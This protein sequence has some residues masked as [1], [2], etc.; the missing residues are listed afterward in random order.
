MGVTGV[1]GAEIG[2]R[3]DRALAWEVA[4]IPDMEWSGGGVDGRERDL[5]SGGEVLLVV[6]PVGVVGVV[7]RE[8]KGE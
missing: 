6:S 4:L 1:G 2:W 3:E 5:R 8:R 7:G